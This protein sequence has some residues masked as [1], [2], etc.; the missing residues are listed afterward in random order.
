[1]TFTSGAT[2][3]ANFQIEMGTTVSHTFDGG[4]LTFGPLLFDND[5]G[6]GTVT[7]KSSNTWT[8]IDLVGTGSGGVLQHARTV[9]FQASKTQTF[10]GTFNARGVSGKLLTINS[11]TSGT[12]A[13]LHT[14][15]TLD[16]CVDWVSLKDSTVDA[17][18][19]WSGGANSTYGTNLTNWLQTA[20][21][22]KLLAGAGSYTYTGN[23]ASVLYDR[24]ILAGAGSYA[25]TGDSAS[26]LWKHILPAG[27][28]VYVYTGDSA[29]LARG[30]KTFA[31]PGSYVYTGDP[32][33][34]LWFHKILAAAGVYAVSGDSASVLAAR[35]L[36]LVSGVYGVTGDAAA[37]AH[38]YAVLAAAGS[39]GLTGFPSTGVG[40]K[41]RKG[42]F[43]GAAYLPKMLEALDRKR[44]TE[45][46]DIAFLLGLIDWE[47]DE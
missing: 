21:Q 11:D 45:E 34:L 39:Y 37:L 23:S 40:G 17:S 26:L 42:S 12:A 10:S 20:C 9:L 32:A 15:G 13:T 43:P 33:A 28:G 35:L 19:Q 30:Y 18:P 27:S 16:I 4:G 8:N 31:S 25:V 5:G 6:S 36:K 14:T 22:R 44:K 46:E 24:T 7:I 38:G 47:D 29:L 3:P 41:A 2:I 1:M